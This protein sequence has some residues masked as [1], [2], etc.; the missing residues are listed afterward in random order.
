[1][2]SIRK[3]K[4]LVSIIIFLFITNF[5]M[6]IFFIVLDRSSQENSHNRYQKGMSAMLKKKVGF[7]EQQLDTYQSLRKEQFDTIHTLFDE[8]RKAKMDFYNLIYTSQVADSTV[9]KA[10]DL[11]AEK[12]KELDLQMFKR[13]KMIRSICTPDQLPKFDT[14]IKKILIRMTGVPGKQRHNHKRIH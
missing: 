13:F 14:T 11:I 1:M 7:T 6:L 4:L 5:A 9:Y 2:N 12:Q 8:L 3:N 10:A